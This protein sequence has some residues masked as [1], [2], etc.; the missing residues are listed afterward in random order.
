[1]IRKAFVLQLH[2]GQAEECIDR[3]SPVWSW[4]SLLSNLEAVESVGVI[5]IWLHLFPLGKYLEVSFLMLVAAD[6]RAA[7]DPVERDLLRQ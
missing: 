3:H 6:L 2:S 4:L 7:T 1:M 5:I